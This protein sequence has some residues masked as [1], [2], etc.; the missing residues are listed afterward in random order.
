MLRVFVF[1]A[2][3]L[4]S[5][6]CTESYGK[7]VT[8]LTKLLYPEW[9]AFWSAHDSQWPE[10]A[11]SSID[12]LTKSRSERLHDASGCSPKPN[13]TVDAWIISDS[14]ENKVRQ[15]L[16]SS[17]ASNNLLGAWHWYANATNR[18]LSVYGKN[19]TPMYPDDAM[20]YNVTGTEW[21]NYVN[22][23][24]AWQLF[25][26]V[27]SAPLDAIH[28]AVE[29]LDVNLR[30]DALRWN[31][32]W[33]GVNKPAREYMKDVDWSKYKYSAILVP[34]E[35]PERL[36]EPLSPMGKLRLRIARKSFE[37]GE[38]PVMI[39]SGGS[40]HPMLT[41]YVEA[42]EMSS[43]LVHNLGFPEHKVI[44]E[45]Q[46]RHTT[47]NLRNAARIVHKLDAPKGKPILVVTDEIQSAYITQELNPRSVKE[48]G[49]ELGQLG[50]RKNQ[51]EVEY[52]PS[53]LTNIVDPHDPMDP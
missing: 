33:N 15:A 30:D 25:S 41:K 16:Q 35:G 4:S 23:T 48:L 37:R 6:C 28:T 11:R 2:I 53:N 8:E 43:W 24:R 19:A 42:E 10:A 50:P 51:Y 47:T 39:L 38:A 34:G 13:C 26:G 46:A 14:D 49:Y 21:Q 40:V 17:H 7:N 44:Q 20:A 29:L 36:D 45:T 22:Q 32:V 52:H 12:A 3:V 1:A 18:M 27:E 9:T 5:V 31:K